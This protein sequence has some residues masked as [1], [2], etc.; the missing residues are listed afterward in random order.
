LR[1]IP[2]PH[3]R[4]YRN[5]LLLLLSSSYEKIGDYKSALITLKNCEPDI[6]IEKRTSY[7]NEMSVHADIKGGNP[8][9]S[10]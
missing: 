5:N 1:S 4:E 6:D 8:I 10:G 9:I 7:L 2:L 3:D